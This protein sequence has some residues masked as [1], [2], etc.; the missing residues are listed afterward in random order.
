MWT[1]LKKLKG[2]ECEALEVFP[3]RWDNLLVLEE[4]VFLKCQALKHVPE[5]FET[6][7]SLRELLMWE[8]EALEVF[9]WKN[10]IVKNVEV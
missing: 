8:C 3:S 1:C 4:L 9:A 10:L 5:G 2:P 7:I 6:L